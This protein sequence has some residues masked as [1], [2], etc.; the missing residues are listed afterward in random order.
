MAGRPRVPREIKELHGSINVTR[1]KVETLKGTIVVDMEAPEDLNEWGQAYWTDVFNEFKQVGLITKTDLGAFK[2]G[3]KWFGIMCECLD[4][5]D[6]KGLEVEKNYFDKEG[7]IIGT[8]YIENPMLKAAERATK[9]YL[10]FC[11]RFGLTPAD[12][13]RII[14]PEKTNKDEFAE[15]D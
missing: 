2:M 8:E 3:C 13:T 11:Q 5:V 4:I 14:L 15:F 7:N 9:L 10:G 1:D 6:A 12:R